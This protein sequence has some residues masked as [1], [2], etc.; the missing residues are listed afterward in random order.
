MLGS[1]RIR[2]VIGAVALALVWSSPALGAPGWTAPSPLATTATEPWSTRA[3]VAANGATIVAWPDG[4]TGQATPRAATRAPGGQFDATVLSSPTTEVSPA[5]VA[6]SPAGTAVVTWAQKDE[7]G[8]WRVTAAVR[9][10]GGAWGAAQTLSGA[11]NELPYPTVAIGGN[12]EAWVIW[13]R[14]AAAKPVVEGVRRAPNSTWGGVE[15]LSSGDRTASDPRV[16]IDAAGNATAAWISLT[17]GTSPVQEIVATQRPA[18]GEWAPPAPPTD[19][20][21]EASRPA[22]A[23]GPQ[24]RVAVIWRRFGLRE[25]RAAVRDPG[26]QWSAAAS[27][28]WAGNYPGDIPVAAVDGNGGVT[29]AWSTGSSISLNSMQPSGVWQTT[30]ST[31]STAGYAD[32]YVPRI[33]AGPGSSVIVAWWG[34]GGPQVTSALARL[35]N[36]DG[37]WGVVQEVAGERSIG[38]TAGMDG[39]GSVF[40]AWAGGGSLR[41]RAYDVSAPEIGTL[42]T[43]APLAAGRPGELIADVRDRWSPLGAVSWNFGDGSAG[44]GARVAHTYAAPGTYR[45]TVTASDALGSTSTRAADVTVDPAPVVPTPTATPVATAT[46]TPSATPVATPTPT[47]TPPGRATKPS[48]TVRIPFSR[49]YLTPGVS[50]AKACR[51]SVTITLK[52]G[53]KTLGRKTVRLDRKCRYAATFT[54]RR[55]LLRNRRS[56]TVIVRFGGNRYLGATTNRFTIRLTAG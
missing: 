41:W 52:A 23:V 6:I 36:R 34:S 53:K 30:E 10:A 26:G 5:E 28:G 32:A 37:G 9:P 54:V 51:G 17:G 8:K 39:D 44:T 19:S 35:R 3:A 56:V 48:R 25:T 14:P 45:V 33:A 38:P 24:G 22:L 18:G 55:T 46:A 2:P 47:P 16:V 15:T 27:I 12:D 29:T 42:T 4:T 11:A 20:T 31:L 43:S 13:V 40:V 49:G 21:S 7:Q 1:G 50:R